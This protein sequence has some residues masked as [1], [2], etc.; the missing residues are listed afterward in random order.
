MTAILSR[1]RW[2]WSIIFIHNFAFSNGHQT[3]STM[4]LIM[5]FR[6]PQIW[7]SHKCVRKL[8]IIGSDNGLSPGWRQAIIWTIDG[9]LLF[10]PSVTNF[11][12]ILV[13]IDTFSFKKMHLKMSSAKWRSFCL[14]LNVLMCYLVRKTMYS[15]TENGSIWQQE[16]TSPPPPPPHRHTHTHTPPPKE[17]TYLKI[18]SSQCPALVMCAT[19]WLIFINSIK[20]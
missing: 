3:W 20:K 15:T 13:K 11:S 14:S 9:M 18:N 1:G 19:I 4:V 7:V 6:L 2:V 10:G 12:E 8:T 17:Y 5:V 16:V